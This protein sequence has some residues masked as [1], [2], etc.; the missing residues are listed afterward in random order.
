MIL[1][2]ILRLQVA[3]PGPTWVQVVPRLILASPHVRLTIALVEV[4]VGS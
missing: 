2:I 3:I 1:H 4:T